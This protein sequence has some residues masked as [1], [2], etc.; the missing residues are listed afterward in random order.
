M[1]TTAI[2]NLSGSARKL[3]AGGIDPKSSEDAAAVMFGSL[4]VQYGSMNA[5]NPSSGNMGGAVSDPD[6]SGKIHSTA[7]RQKPEKMTD[8]RERNYPSRDRTITE[9]RE[10]TYTERIQE[11]GSQLDEAGDRILTE[12]AEKLGVSEEE[13]ADVLEE[14]GLVVFDL[15]DPG[16]LGAVVMKLTGTKDASQLL[17]N[18]DFQELAGTVGAIGRELAQEL[19]MKPQ[20]LQEMVAQMERPGA[21]AEVFAHGMDV[22]VPEQSGE[23]QTIVM[24]DGQQAVLQETTAQVPVS[25]SDD[26]QQKAEVHPEE[27]A[28]QRTLQQDIQSRFVTTEDG[29]DSDT[30]IRDVSAGAVQERQ[31]SL[32]PEEEQS[33][34]ALDRIPENGFRMSTQSGM[35]DG[36]TRMDAGASDEGQRAELEPEKSLVQEPAGAEPDA[37]YTGVDRSLSELAGMDGR[38]GQPESEAVSVSQTQDRVQ[39]STPQLGQDASQTRF[40]E[41]KTDHEETPMADLLERLLADRDTTDEGNSQFF[42]GGRGASG[43]QQQTGTG[44]RTEQHENPFMQLHQAAGTAE[45][46]DEMMMQGTAP[47]TDVDP[48]EIVRQVVQNIRTAVQNQVTSL[49]MQLNPEHLGKVL[50]HLTSREGTVS[51]QFS[52]ANEAVRSALEAQI[53]DLRENL[54]QAGIKVDAIEVT[55]GSHAFEQNLEQNA[56]DEA[57]QS[58]Q[59]QERQ[60]RGRRNL[61]LDSLD[62]LS[63]LMTEEERLA[64]QMMMDN[65]NS[66]DVTA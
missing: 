40:S 15:F 46:L 23:S 49:E 51:A 20:E 25:V 44:S 27:S 39:E 37:G 61:S 13:L 7:E 34:E 17:M 45:T 48:V 56:R 66:M 47:Y 6:F 53:A 52:A 21:Q 12:A 57:E 42:D 14:M 5:K 3:S 38:S 60:Q 65:G 43:M 50:V 32:R 10:T 8:A 29:T 2:M 22:S 58:R 18:T 16:K 30:P 54:N 63:G 35:S 59:Q 4:M 26:R 64:A 62:E 1:T 28:E 33:P 11:S 36:K 31:P 19:G 24:E 41:V 9:A 55:V